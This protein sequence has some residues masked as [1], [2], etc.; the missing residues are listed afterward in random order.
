MSSPAQLLQIGQ[1]FYTLVQRL[2]KQTATSTVSVTTGTH[3]AVSQAIP[4]PLAKGQAIRLVQ[5]GCVW[6]DNA[7]SGFLTVEHSG[8][9][10]KPNAASGNA[11]FYS[12]YGPGGKLG[13][14]GHTC[15]LQDAAPLV[16][17]DYNE[18]GGLD[19]ALQIVG[20]ADISNSDAAAHNTQIFMTALWELYN[21][22][23][24]GHVGYP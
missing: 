17:S 24:P 1:N 5:A 6:V 7:E 4:L 19:T 11:I 2:S 18:I 9:Q 20:S 21:L 16:Y 10:I 12:G 14:A 8:F 15:T 22:N 3:Q 23:T 13:I